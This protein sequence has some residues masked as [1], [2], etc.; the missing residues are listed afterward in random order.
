MVSVY[1]VQAGGHRL[2]VPDIRY[3]HRVKL[4]LFRYF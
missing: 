2:C 4:C 1:E 3:P